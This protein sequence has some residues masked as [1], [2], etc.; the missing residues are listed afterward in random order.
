MRYYKSM[1]YVDFN[2]ANTTLVKNE[3]FTERE[4]AKWIRDFK[5]SF[6][7]LR[8]FDVVFLNPKNTHWFFGSRFENVDL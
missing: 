3:L 2:F 4:L 8:H 6:K 7:V 1:E 5:F